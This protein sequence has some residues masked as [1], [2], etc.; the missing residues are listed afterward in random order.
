MFISLE[1]LKKMNQGLSIAFHRYRTTPENVGGISGSTKR[2]LD[3]ILQEPPQPT[4]KAEQQTAKQKT[5]NERQPEALKRSLVMIYSEKEK[6]FIPDEGADV[7]VDVPLGTETVTKGK[8]I[9]GSAGESGSRLKVALEE[10]GSDGFAPEVTISKEDLEK[11]NGGLGIAFLKTNWKP[12]SSERKEVPRSGTFN[13]FGKKI[14][15][16]FGAGSRKRTR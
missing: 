5:D 4:S 16:L 14:T 13:R 6:A 15:E 12:N 7:V 2:G 3:F 8:V 10:G 11:A 9:S 1:N